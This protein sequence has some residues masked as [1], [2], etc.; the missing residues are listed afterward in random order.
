MSWKLFSFRKSI[1][2]LF[3]IFLCKITHGFMGTQALFEKRK[4]TTLKLQNK[5]PLTEESGMLFLCKLNMKDTD[6]IITVFF[7]GYQ[8]FISSSRLE[9][10][11]RWIKELT[12]LGSK[13]STFSFLLSYIVISF[14]TLSVLLKR[15]SW[16][17]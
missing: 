13:V 1:F 7:L 14:T 5:K 12:K 17:H 2:L 8:K 3:L 6:K 15:C 10:N 4:E 16:L 11:H 9:Q